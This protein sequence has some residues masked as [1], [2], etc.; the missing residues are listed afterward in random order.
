[1]MMF[2]L[3]MMILPLKMMILPLKMMIVCDSLPDHVP[4]RAVL[5]SW[6]GP[7]L[8]RAEPVLSCGEPLPF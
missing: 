5:R 4:L 7:A 2:P 3:K 6:A 1:M 8:V